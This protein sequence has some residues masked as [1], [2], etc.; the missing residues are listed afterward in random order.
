MDSKMD[1]NDK[2]DKFSYSILI[3][4]SL[5]IFLCDP[6]ATWDGQR[7]ISTASSLETSESQERN[8]IILMDRF[9]CQHCD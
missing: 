5:H 3:T 9:G 1:L 7:R 8:W 6:G 2:K 4:C